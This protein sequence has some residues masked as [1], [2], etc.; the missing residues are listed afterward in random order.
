MVS[1]RHTLHCGPNCM[2]AMLLSVL[3]LTGML[4]SGCQN[5]G[6]TTADREAARKAKQTE[7]SPDLTLATDKNGEYISETTVKDVSGDVQK[8]N[9]QKAEAT[10]TTSK[11]AGDMKL[12]IGDKTFDVKLEDNATA[13]AVREQLPLDLQMTELNGNEKY[14]YYSSLPTESTRPGTIHAGDIMLYQ[15]NTLV[16]F[17]QT[18]ESN[19]S[20]T[21]IGHVTD[22]KGLAEALGSGDV[23]VQWRT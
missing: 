21:R 23:L 3:L 13:R 5:V 7:F 10:A 17:Y 19:Y 18:F 6:D 16:L 9:T 2:V 1:L 4:L 14:Y 20:Y 12:I 22:T 11:K 8:G 15:S